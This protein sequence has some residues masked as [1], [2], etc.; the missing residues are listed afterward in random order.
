M[1]G[2]VACVWLACSKIRAAVGDWLCYCTCFFLALAF[3]FALVLDLATLALILALALARVDLRRYSYFFLLHGIACNGINWH[4]M[5]M[6]WQIRWAHR[7]CVCDAVGACGGQ[8][9][10]V[11][12]TCAP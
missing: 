4:G 1:N 6:A 2:N 10:S 3:C 7:R 5:E 8:Q 12:H 11:D 9:R